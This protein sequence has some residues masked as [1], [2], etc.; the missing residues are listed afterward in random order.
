MYAGLTR[1][2][3]MQ[4]WEIMLPSIVQAAATETINKE[5]GTLVVLNPWNGEVLFMGR[6][7]D[8]HP[9]RE[10]YDE[11]ALAKARVS[12]ETG[13]SS[14]E[15]QQNA[16]HLLKPGMTKWGGSAIEFKLVVAFSGVQAIFDEAIS[17]SVLAWILGICRN[18]MTKE[19]GVMMSDESFIMGEYNTCPD[20]TNP[21]SRLK[22]AGK[23]MVCPA[24]GFSKSA[25]RP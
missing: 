3:C 5:A 10:K 24:C 2:I 1:D 17:W 13:L 23:F 14:R 4:A 19:D 20:C 25:D 7:D 21:T 9:H 12:W 22:A 18:E 8:N 15:V 16:P 11:I 6:V